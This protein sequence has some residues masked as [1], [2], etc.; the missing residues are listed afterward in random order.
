[1]TKEKLNSQKSVDVPNVNL[2]LDSG[3][4]GQKVKTVTTDTNRNDP[5]V[6]PSQSA[7]KFLMFPPTV[8]GFFFQGFS[9]F[10]GGLFT[11]SLLNGIPHPG[12]FLTVS[13]LVFSTVL[14]LFVSVNNYPVVAPSAIGKFVI[15]IFGCLIYFLYF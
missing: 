8:K 12:V 3:L 13:L 11:M 7:H 15:F 5:A 1:M 14:Y 6:A 9:L 4:T 10:A 2:I